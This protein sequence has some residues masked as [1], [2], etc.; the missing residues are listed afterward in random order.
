MGMANTNNN[1]NLYYEEILTI[2]ELVQFLR[3]PT[4]TT[5]NNHRNVIKNL[6]RMRDLPRIQ[7]CNKLLFPKKAV[8]AWI[9]K[10]TIPGKALTSQPTA[11]ISSARK[12][13]SK[14]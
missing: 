8:L 12:N 3:I 9:D 10:Q 13:K 5:S 6:I 4:I 2:D 14:R 1:S 7:I 11:D